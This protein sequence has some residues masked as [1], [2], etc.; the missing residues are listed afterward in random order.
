MISWHDCT[1]M[2]LDFCWYIYIYKYLYIYIYTDMYIYI[3]I[4]TINIFIY[5]YISKYMYIYIY[6]YH[7]IYLYIYTY[8]TLVNLRTMV[9]TPGTHG[10]TCKDLWE[11]FFRRSLGILHILD[12]LGESFAFWPHGGI[13]FATV[14]LS[15]GQNGHCGPKFCSWYHSGLQHGI[16]KI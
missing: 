11:L 15:N 1:N 8:W 2:C 12:I 7:I 13:M 14:R 10:R 16:G 3:Y 4:F 6:L 5:I 9:T